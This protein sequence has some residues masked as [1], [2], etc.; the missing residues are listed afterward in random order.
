MEFVEVEGVLASTGGGEVALRMD[1]DVG[2][3][4]LVG[5]ERGDSSR[6]T[7]SVIVGEPC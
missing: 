5:E 6:S 4:A 3:V 2:M 7:R 1:G